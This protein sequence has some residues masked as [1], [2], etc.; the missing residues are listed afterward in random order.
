MIKSNPCLRFFIAVA[1]RDCAILITYE[2]RE[3]S[4]FART[5]HYEYE[6][7]QPPHED[8]IGESPQFFGEGA[9]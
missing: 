6:E 3:A 7:K 2:G 1:P 5:N 4:R 9:N 8:V